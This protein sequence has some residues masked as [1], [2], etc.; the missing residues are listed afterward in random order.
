MWITS[1]LFAKRQALANGIRQVA[2][3]LRVP[4][5]WLVAVM[6]SESGLKAN[7]PNV[8]GGRVV[9]NGLI[10]FTQVALDR[11]NQL[12][13]TSLTVADIGRMTDVQ[14]LVWVERYYLDWFKRLGRPQNAFD[15]YLLTFYPKAFGKADDFV[16]GRKDGDRISRLIYGQ[17]PIDQKSKAGNRDGVL[18]L[19]EF[20]VW[21]IERRFA[22]LPDFSVDRLG[23]A[24]QVALSVAGLT[25]FFWPV[26]SF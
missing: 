17:N 12:Y 3:N 5:D 4:S 14:Q 22:N 15:L 1:P 25:L 23:F 16:I 9:A 8:Q 2:A 10:Q 26:I 20:R 6:W 19:G 13:K 24:E 11:L 18:T 7:N 21:A